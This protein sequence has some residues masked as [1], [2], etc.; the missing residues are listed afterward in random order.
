MAVVALNEPYIGEVRDR[1]ENFH[2]NQLLYIGWDDHLMFAAPMCIP[3]AP[4]MPFGA[5]VKDVLPRLYA[6]HPD[7]ERIDWQ[8]VRW[9]RSGRPFV[10]EADRSLADNGLDH[11]SVVRFRTPGLTGLGRSCS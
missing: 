4:G 3:V 8:A 1:V 2:G 9:L 10:P 6:S 11:K 7:W 5:L